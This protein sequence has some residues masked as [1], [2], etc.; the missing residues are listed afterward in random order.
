MVN[1]REKPSVAVALDNSQPENYVYDYVC[2]GLEEEGIPFKKVEI[3]EDQ[4]QLLAHKA[5]AGSRL[6]VGIAIGEN[7]KVVI[8]HKKLDVD[9]P[10]LSKRIEKKFKAQILGS[11]AARLVKGVPIREI[12]EEL[13]YEITPAP[14][15]LLKIENENQEKV[16][17]EVNQ[18]EIEKISDYIRKIIKENYLE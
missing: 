4:L 13:N 9:N 6:N 15:N 14:D 10:F 11:N 1:K 3:N 17:E 16:K 5:A 7:N 12:P 2:Y 8:H 18:S